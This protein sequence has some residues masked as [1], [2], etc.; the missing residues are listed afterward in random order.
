MIDQAIVRVLL[1]AIIDPISLNR[2]LRKMLITYFQVKFSSLLIATLTWMVECQDASHNCY[3]KSNAHNLGN[4]A[5]PSSSFFAANG[6]LHLQ[7]QELA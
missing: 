2:H 1:W 5:F 4:T 6:G 3:P 7:L